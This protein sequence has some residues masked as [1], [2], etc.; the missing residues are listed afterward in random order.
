VVSRLG[1]DD[2]RLV[3]LT[4]LAFSLIGHLEPIS[5]ELLLRQLSMLYTPGELLRILVQLSFVA[6]HFEAGEKFDIA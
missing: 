4:R 6:R 1:F 2:D 5:V 3:I